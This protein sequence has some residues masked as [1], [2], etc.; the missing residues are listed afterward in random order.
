MWN[1]RIVNTLDE[2]GSEHL[3]LVEVFY[4]S[5]GTPY[6]Y[7]MANIVA[8]SIEDIAEQIEMFCS[9]MD[10]PTLNYPDDFKGDVNK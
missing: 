2:L 5:D 4:D 6:A 7:G 9:A 10:K 8:E 1:H 3:E